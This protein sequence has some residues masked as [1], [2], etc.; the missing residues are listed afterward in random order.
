LKIIA[1]IED[2]DPWQFNYLYYN[3]LKRMGCP[4]TF[5]QEDDPFDPNEYP[6]MVVPAYQIADVGPHIKMGKI[7]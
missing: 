6:F 1:I 3:Q 7:C 4:V 2:F 5:L